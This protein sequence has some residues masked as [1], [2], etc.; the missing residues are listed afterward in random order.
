MIN[1]EYKNEYGVD[2]DSASLIT[3]ATAKQQ[4]AR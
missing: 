2:Q 4:N 1:I 3:A